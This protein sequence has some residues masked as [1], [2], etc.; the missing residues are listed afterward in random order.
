[1]DFDEHGISGSPAGIGAPNP[2]WRRSGRICRGAVSA[3]ARGGHESRSLFALTTGREPCAVPPRAGTL[4]YPDFEVIVVATA[5]RMRPRRSSNGTDFDSSGRESRPRQ[6]PQ[7]G[8]GRGDRGHRRLHRR[9]CT[10]GPPLAP[11]SRQLVPPRARPASGDPTSP[12][13]MMG[14]WPKAW[15]TRPADRP[16]SSFRTKRPS[17]SLAATWRFGRDAAASDR[18]V[19]PEISCR[20]R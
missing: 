20:R 10:A 7:H 16:T 2:P 17:T 4:D 19:R 9:R 18:R 5:R 1:M 8:D 13:T 15:P 11:L 14:G 12:R 6:R 3:R